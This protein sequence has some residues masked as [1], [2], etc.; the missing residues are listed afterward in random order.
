MD[1]L[2]TPDAIEYDEDV[3]KDYFKTMMKKTYL[4]ADFY[5]KPDVYDIIAAKL[6]KDYEIIKYM[7]PGAMLYDDFMN[8]VYRLSE[9][10]CDMDEFRRKFTATFIP[11]ESY[12]F[13]KTSLFEKGTL[14]SSIVN[15]INLRASF[16]VMLKVA[17][18]ISFTRYGIIPYPKG[19]A[20]YRDYMGLMNGDAATRKA[21]ID[22]REMYRRAN[23]LGEIAPD[24]N[25][26]G[27]VYD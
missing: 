4:P 1:Y 21:I 25:I 16:D 20:S 27:F 24:D 10:D 19:T 2:R 15:A 17:D 6:K 26:G 8:T 13:Y 5:E 9:E 12:N 7:N 11:E 14:N 22:R 23:S 18:T 3:L